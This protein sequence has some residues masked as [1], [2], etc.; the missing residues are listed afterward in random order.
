MHR[1]GTRD[2]MVYVLAIAMSAPP[3][4]VSEDLVRMDSSSRKSTV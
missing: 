3:R 2:T 4:A 1:R